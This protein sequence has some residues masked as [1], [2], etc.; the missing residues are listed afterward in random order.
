MP[1]LTPPPALDAAPSANVNGDANTEAYYR[2]GAAARLSGVPV[3]TLRVWERRYGVTDPQ[4]S[5]HG[6]RLYSFD[7]V[8]RLS[9]IKQLVDVGNPIG[10]IARL[11]APQ[12]SAMLDVARG[13]GGATLPA[14]A[15]AAG[16]DGGPPRLALAGADLVRR[17]DGAAAAAAGLVIVRQ[18]GAPADA[19]A[20]LLG[21]VADV[22]VLEL[23]EIADAAPVLAL[24]DAASRAAGARVALVLYRFCASTTLRQLRAAGHVPVRAPSDAAEIGALC[25]Q[26]LRR[27]GPVVAAAP[28]VASRRA[29]PAA[30]AAAPPPRRFDDASLETLALASTSVQCECPRHLV[31]LLRM[32]TSFERYAAACEARHP[33]DAALHRDLE[34]SAGH[35]RALL[36]QSLE[37]VARAEGLAVPVAPR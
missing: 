12:L 8:R 27:P 25:R 9:L 24:I 22:L 13:H 31:E 19:P 7:A 36:E 17:L 6:Q 21:A 4:R 5:A 1:K 11:P 26:A 30:D 23:A 32:L 34:R 28:A 10:A 37:Q 35:A 15:A 29:G 16:A 14:A 18:C 33:D 20:A 3:E 2:S